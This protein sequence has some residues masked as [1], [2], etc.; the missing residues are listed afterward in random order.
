MQSCLP[1]KFCVYAKFILVSMS[2]IV[3]IFREE[4]LA[5]LIEEENKLQRLAERQAALVARV[6]EMERKRIERMAEAERR[7]NESNS[8][9]GS[10][11]N[12]GASFWKRSH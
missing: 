3:L 4:F 11:G 9:S 1:G 7:S 6:E 10:G 12:S 8:G 5:K 2:E